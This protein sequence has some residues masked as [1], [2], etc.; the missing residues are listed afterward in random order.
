[1]SKLLS[2]KPSLAVPLPF[3]TLFNA[4]PVG[5]V[6]LDRSTR[7]LQVNDKYAKLFG[8]T[9]DALTGLKISD[10]DPEGS[11][12][13]HRDFTVFD[14]GG[15]VPDHEFARD[16]QTYHVSV[17]PVRDA[18][19]Q[20]AAVQVALVDISEEVRIG[21]ELAD[22]NNRLKEI[23]RHDHLTGLYNRGYFEDA[24]TRE[25]K[26]LNRR[27]GVLS[28]V[29][30][31]V[32]HF[33]QFN[34]FYGHIAGDQCLA[35]VA[36]AAKSALLRPGDYLCRYGGE[37][38]VDILDD[39]GAEGALLAAGRMS[40]AIVALR[41]PHARSPFGIVTV[42]MGAATTDGRPG[43][44]VQHK[45]DQLVGAA[46]RALYL[47]KARGRNRIALADDLEAEA[48]RFSGLAEASG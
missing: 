44:S 37:E 26:R 15:S 3:E 42:S 9:A 16:G 46:D 13:I 25:F 29:L 14:S 7:V 11:A 20:V 36:T 43:K 47:A 38:L 28:I 40:E 35:D 1:M 30:I 27:T 32:D 23:A 6:V 8:I 39:T 22:A 48:A 5:L 21:R 24:L 31:D 33:K 45:R 12:N 34:D 18:A 4:A 17:A 41:I 2:R 19:G 10:L